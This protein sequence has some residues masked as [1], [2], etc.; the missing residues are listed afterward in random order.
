[1]NTPWFS[2]M[3][4]CLLLATGI[5]TTADAQ[6]RV[7][8]SFIRVPATTD[9]RTA[10]LKLDDGKTMEVELPTSALSGPYEMPMPEAWVLGKS[11]E[12]DSFVEM[13]RTKSTNSQ[14]QVVVVIDKG[15]M[16]DG[17][18]ELI[19][20]DLTIKADAFIFVNASKYDISGEF[21]IERFGIAPKEHALLKAEAS[22][23]NRDRRFCDVSFNFLKAD[24]EKYT[25]FFSSSWRLSDGVFGLVM[26]HHEAI[27]DKLKFTVIR[28]FV[29]NP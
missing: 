4:C 21:G 26:F 8:V 13:G 25:P 15:E 5:C 11:G 19:A 29:N 20:M 24:A 6:G 10:L 9:D 22:R 1:M 18:L 27:D 23:I 3:V 12:D 14:T 16:N 17:K 2:R 7:S 28:D